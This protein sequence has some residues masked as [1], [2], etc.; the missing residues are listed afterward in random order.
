MIAKLVQMLIRHHSKYKLAILYDTSYAMNEI[1]RQ[2]LKYYNGVVELNRLH[3][4]SDMLT[5]IILPQWLK[6]DS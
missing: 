2:V 3:D 6:Y 4:Y 5:K 1:E